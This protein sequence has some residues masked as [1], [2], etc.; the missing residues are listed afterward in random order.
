M[1][2]IFA[3]LDENEAAGGEAASV[4]AKGGRARAAHLGWPGWN[5]LAFLG[6]DLGIRDPHTRVLCYRPSVWRR[7]DPAA[8][9]RAA[10]ASAPAAPPE[11]EAGTGGCS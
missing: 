3:D 5:L 11:E 1:V 6:I 4:R 9:E 2:S 8:R 10:D 7:I